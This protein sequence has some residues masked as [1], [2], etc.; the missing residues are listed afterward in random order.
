MLTISYDT[1]TSLILLY[2]PF[3]YT[4]SPVKIAFG[5]ALA[6]F[7]AKKMG[8]PI[9]KIICA[10]NLNDIVHRTLSRGNMKMGDNVEVKNFRLSTEIV[11]QFFFIPLCW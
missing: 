5:N 3:Y 4:F 2:H 1:L 11:K 9:G 10:T 8:L 7:V 6:C